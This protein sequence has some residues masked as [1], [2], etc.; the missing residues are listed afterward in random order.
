MCS[1]GG[2]YLHQEYL[3]T[4]GEELKKMGADF[5]LDRALAATTHTEFDD[6][7]FPLCVCVVC[8]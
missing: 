4:Q 1:R 3:R 2:T 7:V 5:D 6:A 8:V